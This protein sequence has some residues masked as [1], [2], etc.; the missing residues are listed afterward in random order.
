M[1]VKDQVGDMSRT[2]RV[3]LSVILSKKSQDPLSIGEID[4]TFDTGMA[5]LRCR[6]VCKMEGTVWSSLKHTIF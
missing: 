2:L 5:R 4:S 1:K 3:L 6:R